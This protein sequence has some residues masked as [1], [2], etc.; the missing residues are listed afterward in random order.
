M[1]DPLADAGGHEPVVF[2]Y[3]EPGEKLSAK[4]A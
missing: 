1:T 3:L 2:S 4:S